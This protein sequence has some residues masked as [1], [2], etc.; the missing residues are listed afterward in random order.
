MIGVGIGRSRGG[1]TST[2]FAKY[3][4]ICDTNYS[5]NKEIMRKA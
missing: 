1:G 3:R 5:K 4:K 2:N